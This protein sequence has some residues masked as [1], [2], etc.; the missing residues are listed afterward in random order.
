MTNDQWNVENIV[1]LRVRLTSVEEELA[2]LSRVVQRID[3]DSEAQHRRID[4][5]DRM[6]RDV[7]GQLG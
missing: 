2:A 3:L 1:S 4:A 6:L 5:L 7:Q